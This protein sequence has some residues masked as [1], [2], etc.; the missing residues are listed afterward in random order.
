MDEDWTKVKK[1]M[2]KEFK[3]EDDEQ[4]MMTEQFLE[5]L[6]SRSRSEHDNIRQYC[7]QFKTTADY[8][9]KKGKLT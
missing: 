6:K 9:L 1:M 4:R 5:S 8:L 3:H 2:L 7:R